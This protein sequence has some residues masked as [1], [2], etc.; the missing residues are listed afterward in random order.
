MIIDGEEDMVGDEADFWIMFKAQRQRSCV[1]VYF[2]GAHIWIAG[3]PLPYVPPPGMCPAPI[4]GKLTARECIAAGQ[5]G[6]E[7]RCECGHAMASHDSRYGC[8]QCTCVVV[9]PDN[10]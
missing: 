7:E 2:K 5:C 4:G 1:N 8:S 10:S 9:R 3:R 6:C